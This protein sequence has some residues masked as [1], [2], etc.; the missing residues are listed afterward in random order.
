MPNTFESQDARGFSFQ[1]D[2]LNLNLNLA[3]KEQTLETHA[4]AHEAALVEI[5]TLAERN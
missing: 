1:V 2:L 4:K 5:R 3:E